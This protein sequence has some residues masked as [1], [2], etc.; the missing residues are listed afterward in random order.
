MRAISR[1]ADRINTLIAAIVGMMLAIST[2]A[3]FAQIM[4]R[5][6]LPKLG[7]IIAAP[8]TE[9]VARY[10]MVWVVFLGVA[11]LLRTGRLIAVEIVIFMAPPR[12]ANIVKLGAVAVCLLFFGIVA[13]I[14]FD[15]VAMSAIEVAPVMRIPMNWVYLSMPVGALI[16]IA[17]LIIF[18][19][20]IIVGSR[21]AAGEGVEA[22]E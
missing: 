17:N 15:W 2:I 12:I 14:G 16:A 11:V 7:I 13:A 8:W 19:M 1:I 5:F 18:A 20:E 22:V 21:Q 4:V 3:V 9:E 10:F 6:A